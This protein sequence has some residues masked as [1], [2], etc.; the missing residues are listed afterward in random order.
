MQERTGPAVEAQALAVLRA[1]IAE[2]V[3]LSE[4][5][6]RQ[7]FRELATIKTLS[8]RLAAMEMRHASLA[9]ALET[10]ITVGLEP[11]LVRDGDGATAPAPRPAAEETPIPA[12]DPH[13]I[14]KSR[15]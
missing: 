5:A 9:R 15:S 7:T 6:A 3:H 12:N 10:P 2:A 11:G 1:Q 4:Q 14:A 13:N 8:E